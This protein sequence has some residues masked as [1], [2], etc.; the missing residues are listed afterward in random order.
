M[1]SSLS[2]R[3]SSSK[4]AQTNSQLQVLIPAIVLCPP[5]PIFLLA[6]L[7]FTTGIYK[8]HS[9]PKQE[10]EAKSCTFNIFC[11]IFGGTIVQIDWLHNFWATVQFSV[12]LNTWIISCVCLFVGPAVLW[13]VRT[14]FGGWVTRYREIIRRKEEELRAKAEQNREVGNMDIEMGE[15]TDYGT[16]GVDEGTSLRG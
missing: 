11:A 3:R 5:T 2:P 14:F 1:P 8:F 10:G 12:P 9:L 15:G 13:I 4:R 7:T 16:G 6:L